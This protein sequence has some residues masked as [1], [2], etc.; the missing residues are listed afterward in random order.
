MISMNLGNL[1]PVFITIGT[2]EVRYY[3]LMYIVGF[4]IA[5][6]LV[7]KLGREGYFAPGEDK[8]DELVCFV[9]IGLLIGIRL[10]YVLFYNWTYYSQNLSEIFHVWQGGLSFHG[11]VIGGA[12][13]ALIFAIKNK[14]PFLS[15]SDT[16]VITPLREYFWTHWK[17]H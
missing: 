15:I 14:M 6:Q 2:T 7:R 9:I 4:I 10:G 8:A 13:G 16:V 17:L 12:L 11:G 5:R 1:D 3:S